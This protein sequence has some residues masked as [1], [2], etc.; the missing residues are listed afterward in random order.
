MHLIHDDVPQATQ[1]VRAGV[2]HVAQ[3]LGRHDDDV[4]LAVDRVVAGEQPD[5]VGP[6]ATDQVCVL[7]VRQ[8]FDRRGVEALAALGEGEVDELA[9]HGLARPGRCGDQDALAG[10]Q[11]PT[12]GH[13]ERIE[14]ELVLVAEDRQ[15]AGG[16]ALP[17]PRSREPLSWG[18]HAPRLAAHRLH[19]GRAT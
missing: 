5:P 18:G 12:G 1:R 19:R 3:D 15:L 14:L 10:L 8:R 17:L 16:L 11:R 13:L 6:V 2:Q 7:L 4:G 9:H